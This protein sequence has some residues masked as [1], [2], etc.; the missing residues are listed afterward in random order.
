MTTFGDYMV[1]DEL[2]EENGVPLNSNMSN[3]DYMK[4]EMEA[5]NELMILEGFDD[6]VKPDVK[7]Q[8]DVITEPGK[9]NLKR[10]SFFFP[11]F[12][13]RVNE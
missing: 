4:A 7:P 9:A 10:N 5:E 12:D 11:R 13:C 2:Y 3:D 6:D 1:D 8:V